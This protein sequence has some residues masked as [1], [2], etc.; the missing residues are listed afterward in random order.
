MPLPAIAW[1]LM[2]AGTGFALSQSD[3]K[4]K[5]AAARAGTLPLPPGI[6]RIPKPTFAVEVPKSMEDRHAIDLLICDAFTKNQVPRGEEYKYVLEQ[7]YPKFPWPAVYGDHPTTHELQAVT[8]YRVAQV[9][10]LVPG[11]PE[12]SIQAFCQQVPPAPGAPGAVTQ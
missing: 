5:V 11:D 3:L 1:F 7:F 10:E 12:A 8:Q 9:Y 4:N 6:S 2:G